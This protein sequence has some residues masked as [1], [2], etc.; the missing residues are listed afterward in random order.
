[1]GQTKSKENRL[2][3]Q[4][5][6]FSKKEIDHL[7]QNVQTSSPN[8]TNQNGIT[9]DVFKETVK[10][11]VPSVSSHDDV[12]LKRLYAAFA[13]DDTKSIDFEQFVDGLS[14]FMKG[15]PEEKLELSFK[16][17][18]VKH[19]GYL[20]R[21]DL[22]RVMIQLSQ[23]ASEDDQ[24]NEIKSMVG[25]MFDDLD[26][27]GDGRLTFEEY[28]LSVMKE[29][30]VVDFL[31][32]FL[33]EHNI[34]QHPRIP[35]RPAS[36]SSY[37]SGRSVTH[38]HSKLSLSGLPPSSSPIHSSSRLSV[39]VSQA[40]LLDYGHHSL[41]SHSP[42]S[43]ST[44]GSPTASVNLRN[45]HS[46]TYSNPNGSPSIGPRSPHHL[47]RPTSMT[48]LDAAVSNMELN[49]TDESN[50]TTTIKSASTNKGVI[51]SGVPARSTKNN[52]ESNAPSTAPS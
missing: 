14:V 11:Y 23:A 16:L 42:T 9:E 22:E 27:D 44:P 1:M 47:S 50:H 25:R 4:K 18:D 38:P 10:K 26:V 5:T 29:P 43:L 32:Q 2:L 34:S 15:T 30:L 37:R 17:Y 8:H 19:V 52:D 46:G 28:K 7:R 45:N 21:P 20:T 3:S 6:H 31:E 24:T 39:R 36:V 48:S 41:S 49:N 13:E 51:S 12:F 35:S 40:E 33:A